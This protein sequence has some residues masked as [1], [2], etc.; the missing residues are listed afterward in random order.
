M[1]FSGDLAVDALGRARCVRPL[2][3]S[4]MTI[5]IRQGHMPFQQRRHHILRDCLLVAE[6]I[7][8]DG[9]IGNRVEIDGVVAGARHVEKPQLPRLRKLARKAGADD[10]IRVDVG[11]LNALDRSAHRVT[12]KSAPPRQRAV[13]KSWLNDAAFSP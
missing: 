13:R 7:A 12:P 2:T 9:R 11:L 1:V 10:D 8:N 6:A 4:Q 3:V 5:G